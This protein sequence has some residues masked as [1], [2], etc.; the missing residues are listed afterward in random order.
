MTK[1]MP[2]SLITQLIS[3]NGRIFR[4]LNWMRKDILFNINF[5]LCMK[6]NFTMNRAKK[7]MI[8]LV[9]LKRKRIILVFNWLH[10]LPVQN[11]RYQKHIETMLKC[12]YW[13]GIATQPCFMLK[14]YNKV[15]KIFLSKC[16][17]VISISHWNHINI[18]GCILLLLPRWFNIELITALQYR[19]G[20][21]TTSTS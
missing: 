8:L 14:Q 5:Y 13:F 3:I 9:I 11:I 16:I 7:R 19:S 18:L 10:Q 21:E 4:W 15:T 17:S 20:I 12:Y 1:P 6:K 2:S